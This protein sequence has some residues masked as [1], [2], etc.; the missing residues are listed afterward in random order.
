MNNVILISVETDDFN[1]NAG[2][3][4]VAAI[5]CNENRVVERFYLGIVENESLINYGHGFGY[6][7]LARD[8]GSI[9]KFNSFIIKYNYPIIAYNGDFTRMI[10]IKYGWISESYDFYDLKKSTEDSLSIYKSYSLDY[11]LYELH[12]EK[13]DLSTVRGKVEDLY[14]AFKKIKLDQW[15][16]AKNNLIYSEERSFDGK[17][18]LVKPIISESK[19]SIKGKNV[20]FT[21]SG[22]YARW[23]L[24]ELARLAGVNS[25]SNTITKDTTLLVVGSGA[26]SKLSK[27]KKLGIE[28]MT[29]DDF[30]KFIVAFLPIS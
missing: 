16:F 3:Y 13:S 10:L 2:M 27:A 17:Y 23:R 11:L 9:D 20:V 1:I 8:K 22:P 21:G 19:K 12:I 14:N 6:K 28:T 7:N 30:E 24:M 5:V 25:C 29:M 4:E 18:K 26:G 15:L